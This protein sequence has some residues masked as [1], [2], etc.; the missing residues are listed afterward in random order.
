MRL[1]VILSDPTFV[2]EATDAPA[3]G[4]AAPLVAI[5]EDD[6]TLADLAVEL[7]SGLGLRPIAHAVPAACLDAFREAPP[8]ALVLDW[9]LRDQLGAA[10]FMA[11]RHR[12]PQLP[13]VCWTASPAWRLPQMIR[14]DPMTQVV[15][16]AAGTVGFEWAMRRA[17]ALE[18]REPLPGG[19]AD[20]RLLPNPS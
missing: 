5:L 3:T 16:K 18:D 2:P 7:C 15:D 19:A 10:V 13:V 8:A 6:P 12:H 11:V 14:Q 4:D 20:V 9:R 17:L 1:G